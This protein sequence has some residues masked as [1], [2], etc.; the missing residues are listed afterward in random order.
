V[1]LKV[2]IRGD[3]DAP[4]LAG[5]RVPNIDELDRIIRMATRGSQ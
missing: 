3:Y 4:R 1:K 5:E 2:N